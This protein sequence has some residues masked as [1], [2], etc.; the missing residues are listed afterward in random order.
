IEIGR[1]F[2]RAERSGGVLL[3]TVRVAG[4]TVRF[5]FLTL[6]NVK[7]P[8]LPRAV[9]LHITRNTPI[10]YPDGLFDLIQHYN[11]LLL[12]KFLR[13]SEGPATPL[14][15]VLRSAAYQQLETLSSYWGTAPPPANTENP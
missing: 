14:L 10:M 13:R 11:R 6:G 2:D 7:S 1:E 8:A 12:L 15:T 5:P 9:F 4:D 3:P